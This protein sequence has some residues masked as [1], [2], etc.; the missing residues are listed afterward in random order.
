MATVGVK[1]LTLLWGE[2]LGLFCCDTINSQQ[3]E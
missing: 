1:A 3:Q 2:L